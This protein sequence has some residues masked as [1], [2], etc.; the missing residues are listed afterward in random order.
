MHTNKNKKKMKPRLKVKKKHSIEAL[1]SYK[2]EVDKRKWRW[3]SF[4]KRK[5]GLKSSCFWE[6]NEK[7]CAFFNL[8][9]FF[10]YWYFLFRLWTILFCLLD[11]F[12]YREKAKKKCR[13]K[14]LGAFLKSQKEWLPLKFISAWERERCSFRSETSQTSKS[15]LL[16]IHLSDFG[17]S[18][19]YIK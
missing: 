6:W 10:F 9:F 17:H 4:R 5:K 19:H 8:L 7:T 14:F 3:W 18:S 1:T 13:A 16:H 2:L 12:V 11:W 15:K